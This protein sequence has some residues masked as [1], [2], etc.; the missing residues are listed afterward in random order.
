MAGGIYWYLKQPP[1]RRERV[2]TVAGQVK[3]WGTFSL[4]PTACV[5]AGDGRG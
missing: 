4:C 3:L 5:R 2:R 1:E